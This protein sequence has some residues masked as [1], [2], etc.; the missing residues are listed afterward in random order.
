MLPLIFCDHRRILSQH[1]R[2]PF[3]EHLIHWSPSCPWSLAALDPGAGSRSR[4][5][6]VDLCADAQKV[7]GF[8]G[9]YTQ[10]EVEELMELNMSG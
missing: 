1:T 3:T 8:W 9:S 5:I 6:S 10:C 2:Q 7:E 4:L